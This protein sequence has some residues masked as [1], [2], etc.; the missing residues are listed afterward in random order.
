MAWI[1]LL[2][3]GL[4]EVVWAYTMKLSQGFTRT[5]ATVATLLAMLASFG[6]LSI[7]MKTLP[8]GTAYTVWTGIGAVG[9][10]AVGIV[11]LGEPLNATRV[12]AAALIVSGMVLMKL[13]T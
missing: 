8:L 11:M 2:I 5:G 4:L 3:A 6:L 12:L 10:F 7:S 9:A 13:S 1:F